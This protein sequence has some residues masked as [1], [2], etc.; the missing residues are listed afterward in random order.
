MTSDAKGLMAFW[1]SIDADYTIRYQQWHNCE[2]VPE[3]VSI[4]GFLQGRRYR[5]FSTSSTTSTNNDPHFLMFY[6]TE[7]SSTLASDGYMAALNAP[8]P[9]TREA[10]THFSNPVRSIYSRIGVAEGQGNDQGSNLSAADRRVRQKS[11]TA[12]Y[13]S[14][15]RFDLPAEDS[16]AAEAEYVEK[17]LP[18]ACGAEDVKRARLYRVDAAV[19]NIA[20]SERK[21]YSG[22]PG[23]QAYLLFIEH[24]APP[25]SSPDTDA[26]GLGVI[27]HR[28]DEGLGAGASVRRDNEEY[29]VYWL[30]YA[31]QPKDGA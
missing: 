9:W 16:A 25:L 26:S 24:F 27:F 21:I 31:C 17:W 12:P 4:P 23:K 1:A 29:G 28:G 30:E 18:A 22:G 2:H 11:F 14:T 13:L 8:T 10:L 19:G 20:T 7:S 5:S 6:E 3:R 15:L